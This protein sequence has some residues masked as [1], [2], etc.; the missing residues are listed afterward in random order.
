MK[1]RTKKSA[2]LIAVALAKMARIASAIMAK[3]GDTTERR[4]LMQPPKE[5]CNERVRRL[6]NLT[7]RSGIYRS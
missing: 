1:L 7:Q 5:F 3:G 2:K 4:S 6:R